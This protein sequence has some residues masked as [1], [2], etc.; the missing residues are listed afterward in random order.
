MSSLALPHDLFGSLEPQASDI[1]VVETT[2]SSVLI[3][4]LVNISNPTPYTAHIPYLNIHVLS[5]GTIVGEATATD[6]DI[7]SGNNTNLVVSALWKPSL[8][9][10]KGSQHGRD[11]LSQYLSGYNTSVTLRTHRGSI[12]SQPLVGEALSKINITV[13][14]PRLSLPGDGEDD[15]THFIRDAIFHVFS[16][17]ATFTLVSPLRHNTLYI[18][19][20]NATALYNHTEPMGRIEYDLPFAAPPGESQT[21]KLPVEWSLDSVGYGKLK[22]ALGGKMK[23]DAR[24]VVGVRV[25]EWVETVWYVG[26]GIGASVRI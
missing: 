1:E 11:L 2:R 24:A 9:G 21:P 16:S 6:L 4:A 22:E 18:E 20:V 13:S 15:K 23:L 5:N 12:P 10:S 25:G 7:I 14:A 26:K 17:T 19:S 8:G 3:K